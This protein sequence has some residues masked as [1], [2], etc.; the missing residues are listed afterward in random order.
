GGRG[1]NQRERQQR[2]KDEDP[3]QGYRLGKGGAFSVSIKTGHHVKTLAF[4]P[5]RRT[6]RAARAGVDEEHR[7]LARTNRR[8]NDRGTPS[9]P[10]WSSPMSPR[11]PLLLLLLALLA[12]AAAAPAQAGDDRPTLYYIGDSTVRNGSGNGGNG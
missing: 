10:Y 11:R 2:R 5:S 7:T 9:S 3:D 1:E 8:R 6:P 4:A 12:S